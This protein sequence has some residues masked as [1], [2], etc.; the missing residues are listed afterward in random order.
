M[1]INRKKYITD[2]ITDFDPETKLNRYERTF[3]DEERGNHEFEIN[4]IQFEIENGDH[5]IGFS[6]NA[7]FSVFSKNTGK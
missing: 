3:S 6:H 1:P 4:Q 2:E 7:I 5:G